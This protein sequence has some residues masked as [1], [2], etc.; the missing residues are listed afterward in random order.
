MPAVFMLILDSR[1]S[2]LALDRYG[3]GKLAEHPQDAGKFVQA[4]SGDFE[5]VKSRFECAR[6]EVRIATP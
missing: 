1:F 5:L 4:V 6:R 2:R 3:E